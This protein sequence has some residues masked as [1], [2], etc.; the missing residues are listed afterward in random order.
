MTSF[1]TIR[2]DIQAACATVSGLRAELYWPSHINGPVAIPFP[3]SE[4]MHQ[5]HGG[6]STLQWHVVVLAAPA[7]DYVH[8]QELLDEFMDRNS[9]RSVQAAIERDVNYLIPLSWSNYHARWDGNGV[10]W[11]GAELIVEVMQ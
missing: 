6:G 4:L 5:T 9:P 8:A 3:T 10:P 1:L 2:Q 7:A 11:W